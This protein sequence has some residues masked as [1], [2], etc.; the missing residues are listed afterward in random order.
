MKPTTI[1]TLFLRPMET[2]AAKLEAAAVGGRSSQLFGPDSSNV[3][4]ASH[5][6]GHNLGLWHANY[7]RTD[8]ISP[9]GRDSIPGGYVGDE[10]GDEWIEYGHRFSVMNG[11]QD[12]T[13]DLQEGRAHYTTGEKVQLDWLVAEDGDW[14]SVDQTTATPIRLYRH[15]VRVGRLWAP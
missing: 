8:S 1:S 15:D 12:S 11:G 5:E 3:S 10:E 13:G 2:G 14:M 7:W 6:F 4:I 9:I